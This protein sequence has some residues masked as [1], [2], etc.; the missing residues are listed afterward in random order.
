MQKIKDLY[1]I[2]IQTIVEFTDDC[3]MKMSASLTYYAMFSLSPVLLIVLS[4]AS[5][6]YK[7]EAI[8]NRL[9]YEIKELVGSEL[10]IQIQDFVANSAVSGDSNIAL[11]IGV[12]V[13]IFGATTV[14]T[15]MQDSFNLIWRIEAVPKRAMLKFLAN[16][17]VSFLFIMILGFILFSSVIVSSLVVRFGEDILHWL[18]ISQTISASTFMMINNILSYVLAVIVFFLLFKFLPDIKVK[19]KPILIGSLVTAGL[20]F[21]AKYFISYYLSISKYNTIFGSA[22]SIVILLLYIYYNAAIMYFGAKF[23]KVF[24]EYYGFGVHPSKIAKRRI[25]KF[26]E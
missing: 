19:P 7:K 16:R 3:L 24:T 9:Y 20:F 22:G 12:G 4:M 6:L 10:A 2:I 18:D 23:T 17:G 21:V 8:E 25:V 15:D 26:E 13:L 11:I 5:L 1:K 14:F